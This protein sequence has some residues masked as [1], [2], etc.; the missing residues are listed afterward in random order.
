MMKRGGKVSAQLLVTPKGQPLK[1]IIDSLVNKDDSILITDEWLGY[2]R[3][4]VPAYLQQFDLTD[5]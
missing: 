5:L 1:A 4:G 3:C 2:T